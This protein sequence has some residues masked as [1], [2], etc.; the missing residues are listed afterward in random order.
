MQCASA[1][2]S[3]SEAYALHQYAIV[4][5]LYVCRVAVEYFDNSD[6]A[7]QRKYAF[8]CHRRKEGDRDKVFPVNS[9]A[10]NLQHGTFAT[11]GKPRC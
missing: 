9:M 5:S 1:V 4:D 2:T 6:A 8:K 11:G 10:F 3:R 7:Q